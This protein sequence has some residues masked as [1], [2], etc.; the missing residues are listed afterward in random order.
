MALNASISA[1]PTRQPTIRAVPA[2]VRNSFGAVSTSSTPRRLTRTWRP[3]PSPHHRPGR[4][5]QH[6]TRSHP[7]TSSATHQ[8][9]APTARPRR[10]AQPRGHERR[11]VRDRE[12]ATAERRAVVRADDTFAAK[13]SSG[14]PGVR[15]PLVAIGMARATIGRASPFVE[16]SRAGGARL[17]SAMARRRKRPPFATERKRFRWW[18]YR[19]AADAIRAALV[20]QAHV[21]RG[22]LAQVGRRASAV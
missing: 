4:S 15:D 21:P 22:A 20:A 8:T 9:A 1:S 5:D 6:Q 10:A 3:F 12:G 18:P 17:T 7:R 14:N 2:D 11:P 16:G 19:V 13:R